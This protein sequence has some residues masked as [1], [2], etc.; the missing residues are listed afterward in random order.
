[1]T[2]LIIIVVALIAL[3]VLLYMYR[4]KSKT[5]G[6]PAY[7]EAMVAL[8][9]N[10]DAL[11][12]KKFK[13]AVRIESGLVDAYIRLGD[14]YRRSGDIERAIQI[15]QSLTVRPTLNKQE[16]KRV[17][18]ALVN[19]FL[20]TSRHN[21]AISFLKEILKI[22][23]KDTH[24]RELILKLYED[25]GN[26]G[27][28]IALYEGGGFSR[29][30][31]NRLAFYYASFAH[32]KLHAKGEIDPEQEKEG[33][34]LLK[35]ALK[36]AP[37]SLPALFHFAQYHEKKEDLKK[38][39]DLYTK[40]ITQKPDCAF[41]VIPHLEKVFFELDLF[42]EI[43]P[44]YEDIFTKNNK[45]CAIGIALATLYEKK[46]DIAAST[47]VY[48]NLTESCPDSIIPKLR[49]MKIMTDDESIKEKLDDIEGTVSRTYYDC[50]KCGYG[51]ETFVMLCPQCRSIGSYSL[52]C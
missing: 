10:N 16:E 17:Y 4:R 39:K 38:A 22:D 23:K 27:D 46:N 12:M 32:Q 3:V 31:N 36:V 26:Y 47:E 48:A 51:S 6:I 42:D 7:V 14:L 1:M 15:H 45:N 18:Y 2:V 29:N 44:I 37:D 11:A 25:M 34:N 19:D 20:E 8:L 9:E 40:I 52:L 41:L 49:L 43:I 13:E 50:G 28:C 35:K 33:V 24:A 21:K 30:D 5:S